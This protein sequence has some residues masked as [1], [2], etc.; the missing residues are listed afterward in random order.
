MK[1][2]EI[3][4]YLY[5]LIATTLWGFSGVVAWSSHVLCWR[6]PR[7]GKFWQDQGTGTRLHGMTPTA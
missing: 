5:V 3:E 4:A 7:T 2:T 1:K 6:I